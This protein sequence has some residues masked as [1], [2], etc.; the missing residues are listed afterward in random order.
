MSTK[1]LVLS[2]DGY[3]LTISTE[4]TEL[5]D[6]QLV[7]AKEITAVESAADYNTALQ[8]AGKLKGISKACED[9]RTD[10]KRPV[11]DLGTLIDST[12]RSYADPVNAEVKRIER[13]CG[14]WQRSERLKKEAAERALQ[15]ENERLEN[16]RRQ[17]ELAKSKAN[18]AAIQAK[19][20]QAEIDR[21]EAAED[22]K[23]PP[24]ISGAAAVKP[25]FEIEVTNIEQLYAA[26]PEAVEMTVRK[27]VLND[28]VNRRGLRDIPGV[29][30]TEIITVTSRS[31]SPQ[32]SLQ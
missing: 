28:L 32:L 2:G 3:K 15:A 13:L 23:A 20:T 5:R 6:K 9:S 29:K 30:L 31:I 18:M 26:Y 12:A 22:A 4:A 25:A 17:A 14:D 10:V 7:I 27:S 8:I 11:L 24:V 1:A 16:L 21:A 19:I